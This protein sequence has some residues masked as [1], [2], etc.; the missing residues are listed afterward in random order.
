MASGVI[1][2]HNHPSGNLTPSKSDEVITERLKAAL[3][4]IDI[5]LLDH[6]ILT[7]NGYCSMQEEGL[8]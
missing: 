7:D 6:V 2:A 8:L 4:L 1:I 5:K 3:A